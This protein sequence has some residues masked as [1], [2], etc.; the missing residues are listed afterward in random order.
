MKK[1]LLLLLILF[2]SCATNNPPQIIGMPRFYAGSGEV[3]EVADSKPQAFTVL[4]RR[5]AELGRFEP[6][7]GT[8]IGAWLTADVSIKMFEHM[9]EKRHAVYVNELDL[10]DEIPISWLLHCIASLATPLIIVHPPSN[11]ELDDVPVGDLVVYLAQRL[12]SFNLPMFV[13]FFPEH[14]MTA[15]E[16][17][18]LF[19]KA[20]NAF[21]AHAPMAAFV[22]VA[23]NHMATPQ[24]PFYPGHNAVDWVALPLLSTWNAQTGYEDILQNFEQFYRSFR[25]HK[26]IMILPLGVSHFTRGD[27]TYR[28]NETAAEIQ[29]VYQSL[30]NFPR[31]GLI[32]YA[33]SFTL[34]H[35]YTDDFSISMENILLNAY[36]KAVSAENFLHTLERTAESN[37]RWF[38]AAH[39]GYFYENRIYIS[40]HT[41]ENELFIP[42]PR[43]TT[44]INEN[45]FTD[46]KRISGK[47]ITACPDR[48]VI[49]I[50]TKS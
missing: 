37:S 50:E 29:R 30:Q 46:S 44:E 5:E 31:L 24:N 38:R 12:G 34:N 3:D 11:S 10:G 36:R 25:E 8:Y 20:R 28:L 41:L 7:E 19:R 32:I 14:D 6:A 45:F 47:R 1:I 23:P 4:Y 16:Y 17:T 9:T 43:Q 27:Y 26:P 21:H 13:A 22:W 35:T 40:T 33:D 39:H 15:A 18:L 2:T 49:L 48:Q 42:P